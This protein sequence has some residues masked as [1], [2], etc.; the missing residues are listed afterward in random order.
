MTP[1]P[2]ELRAIAEALDNATLRYG[3]ETADEAKVRRNKAIKEA[4]VAILAMLDERAADK[5]RIAD[6]QS[7]CDRQNEVLVQWTSWETRLILDPRPWEADRGCVIP[8]DL[9]DEYVAGP[10]A[11]RAALEHGEPGS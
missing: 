2:D 3:H 8:Q 6:L 9:F 1:T 5:A 10:Q 4:R 7:R 11:A